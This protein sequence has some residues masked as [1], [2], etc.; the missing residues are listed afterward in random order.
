[1]CRNYLM[2]PTV[3][4]FAFTVAAA[5]A[6]MTPPPPRSPAGSVRAPAVKGIASDCAALRLT[7]EESEALAT[8]VKGSY[9]EAGIK[10][11]LKG[12]VMPFGEHEVLL[13]LRGTQQQVQ[14]F[15]RWCA[16]RLGESAVSIDD[17]EACPAF[18]LSSRFPLV[19]APQRRQPRPREAQW[20]QGLP[21]VEAAV[22][23]FWD[24]VED[25]EAF[26]FW[27]TELKKRR[28][29]EPKARGSDE[30]RF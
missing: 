7:H 27:Q 17:D 29:V 22:A 12:A 20:E 25:D 14:S 10:R 11:G 23:G 2:T 13:W 26:G 16:V 8:A 28:P 5:S 3:R 19:Q 9:L 15:A 30:G 6:A 18:D 1:M 24:A 21:N 4:V